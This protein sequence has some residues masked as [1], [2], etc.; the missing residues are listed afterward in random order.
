MLTHRVHT[1]HEDFYDVVD[2]LLPGELVSAHHVLHEVHMFSLHG[3]ACL[4]LAGHLVNTLVDQ[5]RRCERKVKV[6]S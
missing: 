6:V 4:Q 1:T 2:N 5:L 3:A